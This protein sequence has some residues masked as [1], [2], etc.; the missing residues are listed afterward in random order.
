MTNKIS[1]YRIFFLALRTALVFISAAITYE[2]LKK[3]EIK[4]NKMNPNKN[5]NHLVERHLYHFGMIFIA[6]FFILSL[7]VLL[8]NVHI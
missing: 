5:V 8:F 7:F 1:F 2:L 4:W 3:I 6:D